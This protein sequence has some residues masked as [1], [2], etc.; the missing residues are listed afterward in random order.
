MISISYKNIEISVNKSLY[1]RIKKG[2]VSDS[3]ENADKYLIKWQGVGS[4]GHLTLRG[5]ESWL[6]Y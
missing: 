4:Q 3:R 5:N 1:L 6:L 2:L